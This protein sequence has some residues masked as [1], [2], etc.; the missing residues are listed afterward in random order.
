[1]RLHRRVRGARRPERAL[2]DDVGVREAGVGVAVADAEAVAD[3]RA[4]QRAHADRARLARGFCGAGVQERRARRDRVDGVEHRGELLVGDLDQA[5]GRACGGGGR[6]GDRG[7]DVAG[8]AGDVGEDALV[9]RLAAVLHR[10]GDVLGQQDDAVPGD[11]GGVDAGDARVR[12]RRAHERRVEHPRPLDVDRVALGAADPGVDHAS[13]SSARRTS[14]A[15]T[16]LR[17][18]AE[19]RASAIGAMRSA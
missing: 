4:R 2:D 7:D 17:Y 11:G 3:V 5:R 10:V 8:V 6:R 14:T 19:P 9:A 15:I 16:R 12:V 13:A 1:M 18:A